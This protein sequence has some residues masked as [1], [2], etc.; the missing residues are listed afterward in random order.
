MLRIDGSLVPL[1][2]ENTYPSQDTLTFVQDIMT[3]DQWR[4]IR[5][6]GSLISPTLCLS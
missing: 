4:S 3:A 2:R 6:K 1:F 5:T